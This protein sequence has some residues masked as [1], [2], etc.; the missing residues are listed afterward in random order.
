MRSAMPRAAGSPCGSCSSNH[1]GDQDEPCSVMTF[2]AAPIGQIVFDN[3]AG[4]KEVADF[5]DQI[6]E[7][8]LR[9]H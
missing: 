6:V 8:V 1:R 3:H 2:I 5:M 4:K 9:G 7:E